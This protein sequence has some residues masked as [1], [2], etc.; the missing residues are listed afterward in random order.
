MSDDALSEVHTKGWGP[1]AVVASSATQRG[2]VAANLERQAIYIH[3]TWPDLPIH[4]RVST[5]MLQR[6]AICSGR[7]HPSGLHCSSG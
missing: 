2:R 3:V 6:H 4:V 7:L 5:W 1:G